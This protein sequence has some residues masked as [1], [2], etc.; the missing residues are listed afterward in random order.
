LSVSYWDGFVVNRLDLAAAWTRR[1]F[2][3][4]GQAR[5]MKLKFTN[6]SLRL[7]QMALELDLTLHEQVTALFGPSG[8]G[9]T[10][11]LELVAGLRR[12]DQG[13]IELDGLALTNVSR[14]IFVP[15]R[16]RAIG[17]VPQD[18]ALFP[19]LTVRQNMA[20]GVKKGRNS[21]DDLSSQKLCRVLEIEGLLE[22]IPGSLSG[23]ER[24]R[25]AL[26]RALLASP[27]LLLLDEPL[28]GLDQSLKGRILPYL[29]R[30]RGEL[31][32]PILY[33]TH[34]AAEVISL[35]EDVVVLQAGKCVARG[36][37]A[38]LF[39]RSDTTVYRLKGS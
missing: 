17:Y 28:A 12:A 15:A 10:S 21:G 38:D 3:Q 19:H 32:I 9:K 20:Y 22:R 1:R 6:V 23:G 11:V 26:A 7:G 5:R 14:G 18:L 13:A 36:K 39:A 8:S 34:S 25:V 31:A 30:V 16:K 2:F 29:E 27:K 37:P 4:A 24:Q 33:V 35:C